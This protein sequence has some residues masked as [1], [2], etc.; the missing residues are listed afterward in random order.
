MCGLCGV[1]SPSL[2]GKD[3]DFFQQLMVLATLRGTE[4][5]GIVAVP[6]NLQAPPHIIRSQYTAADLVSSIEFW[7]LR[8]EN[9]TCY[10]GHARAPTTGGY[11]LEDCHPHV[12]GNIIGMHN[13]TMMKVDGKSL[14]KN[15]NDS[16]RLFSS[17]QHKG[18]DLA[19]GAAKGA[20]AL[21]YINKVTDQ[22]CFVRNQHR[23]LSF[24]KLAGHK[25]IAWASESDFLRLAANR[26]YPG[27]KQEVFRL[28]PDTYLTFRLHGNGSGVNPVD[29]RKIE[30][31][32]KTSVPPSGSPIKMYE[33]L[34]G[35][36]AEEDEIMVCLM[37]GCSWCSQGVASW[38]DFAAGDIVFFDESNYICKECLQFDDIARDY[39]KDYLKVNQTLPDK[40]PKVH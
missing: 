21:S 13:G 5:A 9:L 34:P 37:T 27:V 39:A 24:L 20:Y 26:Q 36:F 35:E 15:E 4:G 30:E 3:W 12:S 14:K 17:I 32:K 11:G 23:P 18:I 28:N 22:L 31:T 6:S 8:K 19:L 33:T 29:F 7:K 1:L 40:L 16:R 38:A 10:M 2:D 25:W